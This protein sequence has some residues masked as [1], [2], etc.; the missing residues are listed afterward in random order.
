MAT[1][2]TQGFDAPTTF[3]PTQKVQ[4]ITHLGTIEIAARSD[5]FFTRTSQGPHDFPYVNPI[6]AFVTSTLIGGRFGLLHLVLT[7][8]FLG[9]SCALPSS[10]LSIARSE[11][12]T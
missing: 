2:H 6:F 10:S 3:F 9:R 5:T 1:T 12:H 11:E 7:S 8:F 4:A